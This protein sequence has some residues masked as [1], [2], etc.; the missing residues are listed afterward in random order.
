MSWYLLVLLQNTTA[1]Q[2][3]SIKLY[4]LLRYISIQGITKQGFID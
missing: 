3:S 4:I 1:I 2:F